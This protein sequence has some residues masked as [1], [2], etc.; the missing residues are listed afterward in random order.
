MNFR[1]DY[2][3]DMI[4]MVMNKLPELPLLNYALMLQDLA[5]L[6]PETF[7]ITSKLPTDLT[8]VVIS[9]N[10][11]LVPEVFLNC[12]SFYEVANTTRFQCF[13]ALSCMR[14]EKPRKT[15]GIRIIRP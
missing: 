7:P 11:T 4:I 9:S 10:F 6:Q 12:S 1:S 2:A 13:T 14:S 15:S 8:P 3:T 5:K